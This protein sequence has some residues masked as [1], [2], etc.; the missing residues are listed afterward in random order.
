MKA[1]PQRLAETLR[2]VADGIMLFQISNG[3]DRTVS[4]GLLR[5]AAFVADRVAE[6]DD[7]IA[8]LRARVD[9]LEEALREAEK[10]LPRDLRTYRGLRD[11]INRV[12]TE[13]A[14]RA[15]FRDSETG[16]T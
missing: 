11:R 3:Q 15:A 4:A 2:K 9:A 16:E 6:Q 1:D 12:L 7:E 14:A 5:H 8:A 13:P 10:T